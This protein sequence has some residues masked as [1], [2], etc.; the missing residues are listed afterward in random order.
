MFRVE[1]RDGIAR[2]ARSVRMRMSDFKSASIGFGAKK[3]KPP[4]C[5]ASLDAAPSVLD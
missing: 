3:K 5:T 2:S 1:Y 4:L